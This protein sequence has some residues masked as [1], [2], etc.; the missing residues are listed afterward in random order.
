MRGAARARGVPRSVLKSLKQRIWRAGTGH[1]CG[2]ILLTSSVLQGERSRQRIKN[3]STV[4]LI[5]REIKGDQN[6]Q[7]QMCPNA[8]HFEQKR[9]AITVEMWTGVR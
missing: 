8:D 2:V 6:A 1:S 7:G 3:T 4:R 9:Q 5:S